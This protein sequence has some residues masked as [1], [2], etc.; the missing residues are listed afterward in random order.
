MN[1]YDKQLMDVHPELKYEE[2]FLEDGRLSPRT[3][4][5]RIRL[6]SFRINYSTGS[7]SIEKCIRKANKVAIENT[8]KVFCEQAKNSDYN[9][10]NDKELDELLK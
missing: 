2:E 10:L 8:W 1:K 5:G 9:L 3:I 7:L 6:L 4:Y